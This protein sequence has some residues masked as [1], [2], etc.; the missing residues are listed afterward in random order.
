MLTPIWNVPGLAFSVSMMSFSEFDRRLDVG[1]D[2]R[3]HRGDQ[4]DRL[5]VL[6]RIVGE[7]GVEERVHHQRAVD[8]QQQRVAVGLGLGDGLRADDGVG[9]GA[10]VDDDLL[11]EVLAE[12]L[13]ISRP[14]TSAGPPGANGTISVIGR[15]G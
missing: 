8:R 5:E 9:A 13:P 1:R 6:E 7:L 2:R 10:V 11:A 14:S 15:L 12:L 4:R 3:R